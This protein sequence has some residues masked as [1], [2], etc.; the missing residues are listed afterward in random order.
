MLPYPSRALL[1]VHTP[2]FAP[3]IPPSQDHP[4]HTQPLM[5]SFWKTLSG[6]LPP[7][8]THVCSSPARLLNFLNYLPVLLVS[9][10][11]PLIL[12]SMQAWVESFFSTENVL[13]EV[14]KSL[15]EAKSNIYLPHL[16]C[17]LSC[18]LLKPSLLLVPGTCS[19]DFPPSSSGAPSLV[20]VDHSMSPYLSYQ[21]VLAFGPETPSLLHTP[22]AM[23]C[24]HSSL[25][26]SYPIPQ[27]VLLT[28]LLKY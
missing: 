27:K 21:H 11:S 26:F 16:T 25:L 24:L 18:Q 9:I 22:N 13:L 4:M 8:I 14:T 23:N 10:F 15:H 17:P 28:I 5:L 20:V 2:S 6:P 12:P 7:V 3:V 19:P 1:L